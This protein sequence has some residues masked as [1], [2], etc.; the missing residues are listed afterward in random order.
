M[1]LRWENKFFEGPSIGAVKDTSGDHYNVLIENVTMEGFK[2]N[3]DKPTLTEVDMPTG[4][5]GRPLQKWRDQY[6]VS[7]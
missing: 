4:K 3:N 7:N 1:N 2:Y 5:W 6:G